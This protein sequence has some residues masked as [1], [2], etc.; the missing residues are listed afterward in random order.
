MKPHIDHKSKLDS[1][2]DCTYN[3]NDF[4][5]MHRCRH[6]KSQVINHEKRPTGFASA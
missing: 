3:V 2:S 1:P 6:S 4:I 5:R